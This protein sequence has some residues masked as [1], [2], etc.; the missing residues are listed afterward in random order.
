MVVKISET[1][2]EFQGIRYYRCGRYFQKDGKRLH[3][4]VWES[5]SGS[6]P[7]GF[8]IHHVDHDSANNEIENLK[9]ISRSEHLSHH[10]KGNVH[11]KKGIEKARKAAAIWH[12]SKEGREWHSRH[13]EKSIRPFIGKTVDK[14][15]QWCRKPFKAS[16]LGA[17]RAKFCHPNH[18]QRALYWRRKKTA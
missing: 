10:A 12:G 6:A 4:A 18:K 1:V 5:V 14:V 15:C 8:H 2:Q 13:F 7:K 9:A 11:W 3:I 17:S 16:W